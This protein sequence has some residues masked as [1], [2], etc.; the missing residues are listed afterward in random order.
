MSKVNED[1]LIKLKSN[2]LPKK[3]FTK[4]QKDLMRKV[5]LISFVTWYDSDLLIWEGKSVRLKSNHSV[6]LPM[7]CR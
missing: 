1:F 3:Y 4:E 7:V 2:K 6:V 5:P